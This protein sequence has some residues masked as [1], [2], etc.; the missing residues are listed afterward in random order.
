MTDPARDNQENQTQPT[1]WEDEFRNDMHNMRDDLK[2]GAQEFRQ[3]FRISTRRHNSGWIWGLLL[4]FAGGLLL[5][6]NVTNF[7]LNNWWALFILI[8]SFGS[9]TD[10]WSHYKDQGR[11]SGRVRNSLVSGFIFACIA[12]FFLFNLSL[13]QYWPVLIILAGLAVLVNAILPD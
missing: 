13:G 4:I 2:Q 6:Q 3:E 10:A 8:P 12:A 9:F 7:Q 5:L 1:G 11:V